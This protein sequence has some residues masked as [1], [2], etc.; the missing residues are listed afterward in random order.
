MIKNGLTANND[1]LPSASRRSVGRDNISEAA[2]KICERLSA[3]SSGIDARSGS[4]WATDATQ[5]R[6]MSA[7]QRNI[8]TA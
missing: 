2:V 6:K 5:A 3:A 7:P 8:P 1:A 4:K